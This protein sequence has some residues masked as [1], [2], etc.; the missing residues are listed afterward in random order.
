MSK[1]RTHQ[2]TWTQKQSW[3][4]IINSG[5]PITER[6]LVH[7]YLVQQGKPRSS[8]QIAKDLGIERTNIT[9]TLHDLVN[10]LNL[11]EV[12]KID[13]CSITGINV[14]FYGIVNR[15]LITDHVDTDE[16]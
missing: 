2:T 14:Q 1:T 6:K 10:K 3:R 8:R 16:K 12:A 13:K 11:V 9:R 15:E 7:L 4:K 5:L